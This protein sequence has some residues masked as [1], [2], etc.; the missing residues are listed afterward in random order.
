M[1]RIYATGHIHSLCFKH[2]GIEFFQRRLLPQF[3]KDYV[4]DRVTVLQ[5]MLPQ[6]GQ[7]IDSIGQHIH[8]ALEASLR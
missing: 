7:S 8:H 5:L 1:P 3:S 6:P 2:R 4:H